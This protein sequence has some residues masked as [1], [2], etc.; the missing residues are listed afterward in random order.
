MTQ[1]VIQACS[2]DF[3]ACCQSALQSTVVALGA[4]VVPVDT[5]H[6]TVALRDRGVLPVA[7]EATKGTGLGW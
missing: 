6:Q 7:G 2:H 1:E 4:V 3:T 5:Y